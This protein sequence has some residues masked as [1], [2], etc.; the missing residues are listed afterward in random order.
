MGAFKAL[1][2]TCWCA[3]TQCEGA[4]TRRHQPRVVR[5]LST[6]Q[7]HAAPGAVQHTDGDSVEVGELTAPK[8]AATPL[9]PAITSTPDVRVCGAAQV[10]AT[11]AEAHW[12]NAVEACRHIA[13]DRTQNA[14]ASSTT[15][16]DAPRPAPLRAEPSG[17]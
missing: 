17:R 10:D 12:Q 4:A 2:A 5:E 7:P 3:P 8:T 1:F 16:P 9:N 6:Q 11:Q 14:A 15:Q 13:H